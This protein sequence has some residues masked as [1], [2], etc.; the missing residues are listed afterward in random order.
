MSGSPKSI[1]DKCC[2]CIHWVTPGL[3]HLFSLL[4]CQDC[5]E[6]FF[7]PTVHTQLHNK[8]V[9]ITNT[10]L[11]CGTPQIQATWQ[12]VLKLPWD[13][14][15]PL[16]SHVASEQHADWIHLDERRKLGKGSCWR[17]SWLSTTVGGTQR[18]CLAETAE[19]A[20]SGRNKNREW[21]LA[22]G[23]QAQSTMINIIEMRCAH[24][25]S[26]WASDWLIVRG[27]FQLIITVHLW[28]FI[29]ARYRGRAIWTLAAFWGTFQSAASPFNWMGRV[30]EEV[31][32]TFGRMVSM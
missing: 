26:L 11:R 10:L 18:A 9:R 12:A 29:I 21:G 20:Y 1:Y 7:L 14:G 27:G 32:N 5:T 17:S 24:S 30:M 19:L 31:A 22:L 6:G 2:A 8:I 28:A 15:L 23:N 16:L 25:C 3:V 13:E 4:H